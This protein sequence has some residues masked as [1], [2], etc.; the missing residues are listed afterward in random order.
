MIN[1]R[2]F[3]FLLLFFV[4]L[5][6]LEAQVTEMEVRIQEIFLKGTQ[7]SLMGEFDKAEEFYKSVLTKDPKN[8]MSAFELARALE[9]QDKND[10][11]IT[12]AKRA[13]EIDG[14]NKWFKLFLADLYQKTEDNR[15]GANVYQELVA[16]YPH[17]EEYYLKQAFFLVRDGA[18]AEAIKIYESL[19]AKIGINEELTRRKH[20]L[21]IGTGDTEGAANELKKLIAAFPKSKT[22][23]HLLADFYIQA[24]QKGKAQKVYKD[25]LKMDP[26]DAAAKLAIAGEMK[27]SGNDSEYL[28]SLKPIFENEKVGLDVKIKELIPMIQRVA[29]YSDVTLADEALQLCG[30]LDQVHPEQAKVQ[31]IAADLYYYTDRKE[32]A[33]KRYEK[34]LELDDRVYLVW[35]QLLYSQK[36]LGDF[37]AMLETSEKAMDV[38]PN[39]G[40]IYYLNGYAA[41]AEGNHA[42][43]LTSLQQA[44]MMSSRNLP[45]NLD[46]KARMGWTYT[47]MKKYDKAFAQL[48]TALKKSNG[49]HPQVLENLGDL[50]F[51]Q[52]KTKDAVDNWKQA[53]KIFGTKASLEKKIAEKALN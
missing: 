3:T 14:N 41:G 42:D 48:E 24:N 46:V 20:T 28:S 39:Q 49:N 25:I 43:A 33:R 37:K 5:F 4:S 35:E 47:Q 17:F 13:I 26:D 11:A 29:K 6:S 52:G 36:D 15:A 12:Y 50:Y 44:A 10:E 7:A 38:F 22:Y 40:S 45:L 21:L 18:P 53:L 1:C 32:E 51:L 27:K 34:T 23:Q 16:K 9:K 30:I 19:E 8:G 31:S 2:Y